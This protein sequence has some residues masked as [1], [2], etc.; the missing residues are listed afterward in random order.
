MSV[1]DGASPDL[2]A[3][4]QAQKLQSLAAATGFEWQNIKS[5]FD[6]LD[7]EIN[8]VKDALAHHPQSSAHITEELG[9]LLFVTTVLCR[10]LG[11]DAETV[12]RQ[13]N[14]KFTLRFQKM[15]QLARD[16]NEDFSMLSI[17]QKRQ[18]WQCA[19]KSI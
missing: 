9:D 18:L 4:E 2:S 17:E 14:E 15:E 19:K 10:K 5:I 11:L 3:L 12:L 1:L 6:K 16:G 8:E 13:A 7:E